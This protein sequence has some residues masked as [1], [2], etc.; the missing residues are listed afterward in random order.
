MF[1]KRILLIDIIYYLM[2]IKKIL[3]TSIICIFF[4][5]SFICFK[6]KFFKMSSFYVTL[7]SNTNLESNKTGDFI[8]RLPE[9]LNLIGKKSKNILIEVLVQIFMFQLLQ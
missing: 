4:Y 1:I 5:L 6:N 3:C 8:V 7:P 2:A 9:K